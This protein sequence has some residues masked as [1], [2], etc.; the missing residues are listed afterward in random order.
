MNIDDFLDLRLQSHISIY[1]V[2]GIY[3]S[4][5]TTVD[6]FAKVGQTGHCEEVGLIGGG[7]AY[8][9]IYI[10]QPAE[11]CSATVALSWKA[12]LWFPCPSA[13]RHACMHR[14]IDALCCPLA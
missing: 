13:M 7:R 2:I 1:K 12:C 10:I 9:Y 8:I 14:C 3:W 4:Y 6:K 5:E 11:P